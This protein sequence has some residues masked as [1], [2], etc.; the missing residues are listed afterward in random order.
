MPLFSLPD[1]YA[2]AQFDASMFLAGIHFITR[3]IYQIYRACDLILVFPF[4][5]VPL[6]LRILTVIRIFP[7][8]SISALSRSCFNHDPRVQA[9]SARATE[10]PA[11]RQQPACDRDPAAQGSSLQRIQHRN[12]RSWRRAWKSYPR[13]NCKSSSAVTLTRR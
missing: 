10:P 5:P 11:Y 13:A 3:M 2:N 12:T 1:R 9:E 7:I 6:F 8:S 4:P